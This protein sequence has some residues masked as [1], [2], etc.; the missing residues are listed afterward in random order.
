[1]S[2]KCVSL[3]SCV[4]Q[5]DLGLESA[6][7]HT[8][9]ANEIMT[10]R[11]ELMQKNFSKTKVIIGDIWEKQDEIV[12]SAKSILGQEQLFAMIISA[13]CQGQ[14]SN[15]M[16]RISNEIKKG[17]RPKDDP[18][19]RLILPALNIVQQLNPKCLIIENVCAMRYTCILNEY[20]EYESILSI[21][22]RKLSNY[23]FRSN[24]INVADYGVPQIRKRLITI[25][26]HEDFTSECRL[27][28]YFS[29]ELSYF[30]AP[31]THGVES[32]PHITLKNCIGHLP[33]LDALYKQQD[34]ND[35]FHRVPK[36]NKIQ[37]FCMSNT[38][39]NDTAFNNCICVHCKKK[40]ENFK[41][42]YC[43]HCGNFLPRPRI[44]SK[45]DDT[46]RL[47]KAFKTAYRRM[48]WNRPGNALTTNS[49]V[50]SS[51]VKGHP[52]QNRVLS[53]REIMIVASISGY[54]GEVVPWK[55]EFPDNNPKLIREIIG[56]CIPPKLTYHLGLHLIDIIERSIV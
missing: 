13:P 12:S 53:L 49:G 29:N 4:G 10:E 23:V 54:P 55:Y 38:C 25:G 16:G 20:G 26:V 52:E 21:I 39:E 40:T 3:F 9:V 5:G 31:K 19:N 1:M 22:Y 41:T 51:D 45:K 50:I 43:D 34:E 42:I 27:S 17:K 44:Y 46:W 35:I 28:D 32:K 37:Y 36:W 18:R 56:E 15:G 7:I 30:H 8:I 14:S 48:S 11:A 6:G 47:V 2:K 24:I 33:E